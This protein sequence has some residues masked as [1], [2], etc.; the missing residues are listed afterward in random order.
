MGSLINSTRE[1][2]HGMDPI[3]SDRWC[4][5]RLTS[6]CAIFREWKERFFDS[7]RV[8]IYQFNWSVGYHICGRNW[9]AFSLKR[10]SNERS[11]SVISGPELSLHPWKLTCP[12][13]SE[14]FS[15]E[16][17]SYIFQPSI[18]RGDLLVF[19]FQGSIIFQYVK[20]GSLAVW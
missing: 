9:F 7:F 16:Y 18:F 2:F 11:D 1:D 17:T 4:G 19:S 15:R 14:H 13:K 12:L 5:S 8:E 20:S 10:S 3:Y 6:F